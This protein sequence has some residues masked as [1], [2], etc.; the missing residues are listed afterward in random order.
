MSG[1]KT[2]PNSQDVNEFIQA[3][4][5]SGQRLDAETLIGLMTE[6]TG[7]PP[8][9][10]GNGL[11]G[12]GKYHYKYASGREGD[13]FLA[14]FSPRKQNISIYIVAGFESF[15]KTLKDLGKHS[16]GKGCLYVKT[17]GDIQLTLLESMLTE[18]I[19]IVKQRY[20]G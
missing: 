5:D 13:W 16:I 1:N 20:S 11:I 7:E 2:I 17:L 19:E 9:M 14:G 10:W 4:N 15:E 18:S 6:I 3:L 8:V 12:F